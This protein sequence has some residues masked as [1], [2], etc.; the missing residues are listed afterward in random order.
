MLFKVKKKAVTSFYMNFDARVKYVEEMRN[1]CER[2]VS[3]Y[4]AKRR[5]DRSGEGC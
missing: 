3:A 2:I 4:K 5:I 1:R